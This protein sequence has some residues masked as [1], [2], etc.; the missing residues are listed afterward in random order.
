MYKSEFIP[1]KIKK[2]ISAILLFWCVGATAQGQTVTVRGFVYEKGANTGVPGVPILVGKPPKGVGTTGADGSFSI[3][4]REGDELT[5]QSLGYNPAKVK[6]RTGEVI[7]VY[8]TVKENKLS[9]Q[10][11]IGYQRKSRETVTGST[12][13]ISGKELQ[14][15]PVAN[16]M[17]LLQGK[18][19][20][21]NIQNNTGAPGYAG[22]IQM[23]GVSTLS[24]SG[25]GDN[26]FLTPT[27]PLYVIDGVPVDP[28]SNYEYGFNQAGPGLNPLS[29]IPQEDI[30]SV[31]VLKDAQATALYGSRG[32]YG[33]ILINTKRGKSKVPIVSYTGNFFVSIPPSLRKVIGGNGERRLRI[34]QIM[35]YTD[36]INYAKELVNSTPFLA[37]SLNPYYNN[38][39]DWQGIFYKYTYNTTHNLSVSGGD[40][41]FNYK[42]NLGYYNE[43]GILKNTDFNRYNLNTNMQY[44]PTPR[45][46]VYAAIQAALGQNSKGS[47]NGITQ[48]DVGKGGNQSSL[49]PAPSF[50]SASANAIAALRNE[51]VN[52]TNNITTNIDVDYELMTGLH[53]TTNFSYNYTGETEDNFIPAAIN[54]NFDQVMAYN[55]RRHVLY[56]RSAVNYFKSFNEKHNIMLNVFT[57]LRKSG[58]QASRMRLTGTASDQLHGPVGSGPSNSSGGVLDN[59]IDEREVAVASSF[60]YNYMTKYLIDLSFRR[61]ASSKLGRTTPYSNNPS[62]GLR[63]NFNKENFLKEKTW[64]DYGALRFTWGRNVIPQ[65]SIFDAYGVYDDRNGGRYNDKPMSGIDYQWLPNNHLRALSTTQYN[66][67]LDLGFLNGKLNMMFDAYARYVD[68][69]LIDVKLPSS[70]G[71]QMTKSDESGLVNLGFEWDFTYRPLPKT[72][73]LQ[74]TLGFNGALNKE[75]IR[76]LPNGAREMMTYDTTNRQNILRR[77]GRN[78][79]TNVLL[80]TKGAYAGPDAVQVDPA[81]GRPILV[82][83]YQGDQYWLGRQGDPIWTDLNGDYLINNNDYIYA[84]NSQPL[85]TGGFT[86]YLSYGAWSLNITGSYTLVRS[87]LNNAVQARFAGYSNPTNPNVAM[88]PLDGYDYWTKT[89]DK[90]TYPNPYDY[91][92]AGQV[93]PYRVDQTLFEE[94]GSYWKIQTIT[95]AYTI[96]R[97]RTIRWGIT[98]CRTY[99]TFTNPFI[100]SKY[101]GPNPEAVSALGRDQADGYPVR[102][103]VTLGLNVQF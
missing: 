2:L 56:N 39:T 19:A 35:N 78:A 30:E 94:D 12:V 74:W 36:S 96:P 69:T 63:W 22:T 13:L 48:S 77:V 101:S 99:A 57:E 7:R 38:S 45:L 55:G 62:V 70:S 83:N 67:G 47:G 8:L 34:N 93:R 4:V 91:L 85:F 54:N 90:S 11:V 103:T 9:E 81:T 31:Q 64:L 20:G 43:K 24:I 84:G 71:F 68:H 21:L 82:L 97:D 100:F 25:S 27:S 46:K 59:A 37:D 28:N 15:A 18:V 32:A 86:S 87:I 10:V 66:G 23:R 50:Y 40:D 14:N 65:G 79:Y 72:S 58:G 92:R 3:S 16:V 44:R 26:A 33:V 60:S 88:V 102:K 95:L 6:A 5:F 51:N 89:G 98:S 1:G 73:K 53:A 61:D 29:L 49:L 17:E 52:K 76:Y 42:V 41:R 80:N 75:F